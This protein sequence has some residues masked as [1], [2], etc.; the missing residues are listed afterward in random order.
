MIL[1][2]FFVENEM[3][4]Y[5]SFNSLSVCKLTKYMSKFYISTQILQGKVLFSGKN[6]TTVS[7]FTRPPVATVAT[8]FKF[9]TNDPRSR[10][11]IS[12]VRKRQ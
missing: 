3:H 5:L 7:N 1:V 4:K 10:E 11:L 6:Y 9:A 8:N 2:L 12:K